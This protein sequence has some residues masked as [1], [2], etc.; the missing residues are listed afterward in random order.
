[1]TERRARRE[2]VPSCVLM[3]LVLALVSLPVLMAVG[4]CGCGDTES[5]HRFAIPRQ[6]AVSLCRPLAGLDHSARRGA[7]S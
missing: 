2:R 3:R 6:S 7:L 5:C 1:M 4:T